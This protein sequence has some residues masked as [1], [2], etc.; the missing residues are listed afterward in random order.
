VVPCYNEEEV[1]PFTIHELTEALQN[2]ID[3]GLVASD[4]KIVLVDDGS[5]DSTWAIIKKFVT[6]DSA[7]VIG[8]A[9][10]R[11]FGHGAALFAGLSYAREHFDIAITMDADL[12]D[13][14]SKLPEFITAYNNGAQVVYGVRSDRSSDSFFKRFF[15]ESF[16]R[17][18]SA[19]GVK[20]VP[21]HAE[22]RLMSKT[23]LNELQHY[24]E[25]NLYLRGIIAS[26]GFAHAEVPYARNRRAA[27][28]TKY[29]FFG[30]LKLALEAITSFSVAPLRFISLTGMFWVLITIGF[31]VYAIASKLLGVATPGW[32]A[33]VLI[34][35]LLGGVQ[36]TFMGI[37][38]EYV[39]KIYQEV[40]GRPRYIIEQIIGEKHTDSTRQSR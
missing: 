21:N 39:G 14:I 5:V 6:E 9:F 11:N 30:P 33:T 28:Q 3:S 23:V 31:A 25:R 38:G 40:K 35:S 16:Y 12:Q 1:L 24:P 10:S 20:Q 7:P 27:G 18:M 17:F 37:I 15:A 36:I 8:L 34:I 29:S 22:Y 26:M 2:L 32:T 4:S 19:L 13:D